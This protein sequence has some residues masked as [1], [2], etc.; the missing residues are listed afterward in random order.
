MLVCA[1]HPDHCI[2]IH[3]VGK[4]LGAACSRTCT[5]SD[6]VAKTDKLSGSMQGRS[7]TDVEGDVGALQDSTT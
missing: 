7:P 2:V 1:D 6:G 4:H 3:L 5:R